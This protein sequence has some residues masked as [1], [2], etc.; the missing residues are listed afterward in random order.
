LIDLRDQPWWT[1]ADR[2]ELD[3]LV[4]QL[5]DRLYEHKERCSICRTEGS[6]FCPATRKAIEIVIEWR[7]VRVLLS[8]ATWLRT[9]QDLLDGVVTEPIAGG[10]R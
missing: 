6:A 7:D 8:Q 1:P 5:V 10:Q 2:A 9:A 4:R 3:L